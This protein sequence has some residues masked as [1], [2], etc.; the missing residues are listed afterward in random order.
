MWYYLQ[1]TS[2]TLGA[3][4][5][6]TLKEDLEIK[7]RIMKAW[8]VL[9]A[10]KHF[11]KGKGINLRTKAFLYIG[12]PINTLLWKAESWNLAKHNLKKLSAFHHI[13]MRW[14]LGIIMKR[15]KDEQIKNAKIR[16][17]FCNLPDI[18]YYI[19]KR[20]WTYIGKVVRQFIPKKLMGAWLNCPRKIGQ[21]QKSCCNLATTTLQMIIPSMSKDGKFKDFYNL[22]SNESI[23]INTLKIWR[24]N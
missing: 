6:D 22:A 14:I 12:G 20:V 1:T 17:N 3:L 10:M 11:F 15:G 13:A 8:S 2:N 5:T 24:T 18:T 7:T 19:T 23:R 21:P 9:G 16:K 4:I